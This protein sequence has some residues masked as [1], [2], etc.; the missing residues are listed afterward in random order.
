MP[1][2][3]WSLT[4]VQTLLGKPWYPSG[5]G[6]PPSLRVVSST[7]RSI[8]AV[9]MPGRVRAATSS[10]TAAFRLPLSRM[11]SICARFFSISRIGTSHPSRAYRAMRSSMAAWH[12][13]YFSPLPHQ[14]RSLRFIAPSHSCPFGGNQPACAVA[15]A[16]M[17]PYS[18]VSTDLTTSFSM[19]NAAPC[20]AGTTSGSAASALTNE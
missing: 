12:F 18:G 2:Q 10:S 19:M 16:Y 7:M 8:S 17:P 11:P 4:E 6:T 15:S 3:T 5:A 1:W 20:G 14:Q 13:L 9:V